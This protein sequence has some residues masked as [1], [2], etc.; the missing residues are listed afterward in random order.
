MTTITEADVES[1]AL[2]WPMGLGWQT[3][4]GSD[5]GDAA[6]ESLSSVQSCYM[7]LW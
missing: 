1:A 7:H 3:V 6:S 4:Q 5:I 2:E